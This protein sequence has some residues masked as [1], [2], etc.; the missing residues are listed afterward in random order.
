MQDTGVQ[1]HSPMCI[2][3]IVDSTNNYA[4]RLIDADKAEAGLTILARTQTA[5]KGQRGK[6]W[7]G[8]LDESLLMSITLKP[9]WDLQ[10]QAR[11]LAAVA[12]AICK[13]VQKLAVGHAVR[14]KWPNDIMIGDK[15]AAGILIENVVRGQDW[16][17]AVVGIGLN[18]GQEA[19]EDHLPHATSLRIATQE[20]FKVETVAERFRQSIMDEFS[21]MNGHIIEAYNCLLYKYNEVQIFRQ[22]QDVLQGTIRGMSEQGQLI[23]SLPDGSLQQY[24]HGT[25]EWVWT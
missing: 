24:T 25:V 22:N 23:V 1:P 4:M 14:I 11:F 2:L 5:G 15:K 20:V 6:S 13:E 9:G 21:V 18:V 10:H 8:A 19:F 16:Q 3:D 17:W 7:N 12:T